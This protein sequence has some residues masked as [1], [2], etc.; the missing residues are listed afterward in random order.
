MSIPKLPSYVRLWYW[1]ITAASSRKNAR[2]I[3]LRGFFDA[4][5]HR[6]DNPS[7]YSKLL[8]QHYGQTTC[9]GNNTNVTFVCYYNNLGRSIYMYL[10]SLE[11]ENFVDTF[12]RDFYI[13]LSTLFHPLYLGYYTILFQFHIL[14]SGV[15][16]SAPPADVECVDWWCTGLIKTRF[17]GNEI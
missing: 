3:R 2:W 11:T 1:L 12:V 13:F 17:F 6:V 16:N 10:N 8:K 7:V 14:F 9:T 5:N 4:K 15:V